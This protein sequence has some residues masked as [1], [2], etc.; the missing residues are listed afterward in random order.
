[1]QEDNCL[2]HVIQASY[3]SF[4]GANQCGNWAAILYEGGYVV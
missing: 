3:S 2:G 4:T 1:M